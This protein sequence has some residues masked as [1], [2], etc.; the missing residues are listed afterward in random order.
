MERWDL[1]NHHCWNGQVSIQPGFLTRPLI[2]CLSICWSIFHS[3]FCLCIPLKLL[4]VVLNLRT[5]SLSRTG[6]KPALGWVVHHRSGGSLVCLFLPNGD[7]ILPSRLSD[8]GESYILHIHDPGSVLQRTSQLSD[9]QQERTPWI[10]SIK[11]LV[12]VV[13]VRFGVVLR[14]DLISWRLGFH[15]KEREV[16]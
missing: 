15:V 6:F 2:H 5:H 9:E 4:L 11:A 1:V 16:Q 10:W 14:K 7:S 12:P 3:C 8:H 13:P